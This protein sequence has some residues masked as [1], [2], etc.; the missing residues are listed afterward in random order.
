MYGAVLCTAIAVSAAAF[1][2][3]HWVIGFEHPTISFAL[4]SFSQALLLVALFIYVIRVVAEIFIQE[5][6]RGEGR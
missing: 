3:G 5:R 4:T 1:G 2:L 6:N